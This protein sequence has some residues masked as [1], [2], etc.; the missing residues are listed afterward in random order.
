MTGPL[1]WGGFSGDDFCYSD[2][3]ATG[4]SHDNDQ[5]YDKNQI[6]VE[7]TKTKLIGGKDELIWNLKLTAIFF[8]SL[9]TAPVVF[10]HHKISISFIHSKKN[11]KQNIK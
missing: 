3:P 7:E 5:R 11:K 2:L 6:N 4:W 1:L 10:C 8:F 9:Q